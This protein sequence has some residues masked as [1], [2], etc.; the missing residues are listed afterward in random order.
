MKKFSE[1][2]GYEIFICVW[3]LCVFITHIM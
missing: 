2:V 3:M 1:K